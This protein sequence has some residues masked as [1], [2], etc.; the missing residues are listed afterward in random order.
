MELKNCSIKGKKYKQLK[1]EER[2]TEDRYSP[3]AVLGE[4]KARGLKFEGMVC[5]KTLYNYID[6]GIFSGII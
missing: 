5:T 4:I 3:D 2:Y 6:M 1:K